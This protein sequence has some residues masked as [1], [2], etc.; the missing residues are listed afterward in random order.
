VSGATAKV[1]P[2]ACWKEEKKTKQHKTDYHRNNI[3]EYGGL[4]VVVEH[5][6]CTAPHSGYTRAC[7]VEILGLETSLPGKI[8]EL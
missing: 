3:G 5:K 7:C 2:I 4:C 6:C 8:T 1:H